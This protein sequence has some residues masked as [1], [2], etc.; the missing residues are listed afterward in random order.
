MGGVHLTEIRGTE[1]EGYWFACH[2]EIEG[3]IWDE[4]SAAEMEASIHMLTEV[5]PA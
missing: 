5:E 1:I 2:C 3:Q 4:K